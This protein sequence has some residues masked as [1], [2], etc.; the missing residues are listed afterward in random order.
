MEKLLHIKPFYIAGISIRTAN[1]NGQAGSDLTS[2]WSRFY[3]ESIPM[4]ISNPI[5]EEVY[6]VYTKYSSDFLGDYTA[7]IGL[8]IMDNE[9][10]PKGL[11]RIQ[12]GGGKYRE[13]IL[14]GD[15]GKSIPEAWKRIWENDNNLKRR[16]TS[17]FEVYG[18]KSGN[19]TL[20]EVIINLAVHE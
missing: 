5:G 10:L 20:S 15:P 14:K 18:E 7:F 19:G 13:Y 11:E 17:D 6:A 1:K 2:L 12:I 4:K 3:E 16:Y 9:E 8:K